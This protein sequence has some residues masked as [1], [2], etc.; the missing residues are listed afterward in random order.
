[1]NSLDIFTI[2]N[3]ALSSFILWS[4]LQGYESNKQGCPFHLLFLPLPLVLSENI[5]HEFKRAN[6]A[7]GLQTWI[8]RNQ[9]SL[10]RIPESVEKTSHLTKEAI[11]FGCSN[12][13]LQFQNDGTVVSMSK[14][15]FK[16]NLNE[17]SEELKDMES[18]S[19]KLGKW[20]SQTNSLTNILISLG[21]VYEAMEHSESYTL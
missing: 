3:P 1:M 6:A 10:L 4:F 7:T 2:T 21:L 20:L 12:K 8:N 14:G 5:R 16:K 11:I 13:I 17:L 15:I 18:A 19:K 9:K